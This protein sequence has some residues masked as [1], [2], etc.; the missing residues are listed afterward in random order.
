MEIFAYHVIHHAKP[1]QQQDLTA[2]F[3]VR[4]YHFYKL[5]QVQKI[6]LHLVVQLNK[7]KIKFNLLQLH[8]IT[9]LV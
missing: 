5:F 7:S 9:S 2:V 4:L 6:V 3:L 8:L 1:V